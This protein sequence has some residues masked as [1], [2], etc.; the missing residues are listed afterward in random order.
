MKK[1]EFIYQVYVLLDANSPKT[2]TFLDRREPFQFLISVILSAQTTDQTVNQ[3]VPALF[4]R[5]PD[6]VS[7][8]SADYEEVCNLIRRTGFYRNKAKNIIACS[9]AL[10]GGRIP[11]TIEELVKLPGV[12]R[13]TANCVV[14]DIYQGSAVIVDTHVKRVLKRL[15]FTS[16]SDPDRI[17]AQVRASLAEEY[18]Y[19]FSMIVNLHGRLIC[20]ARKPDCAHCPLARLCPSKDVVG[21]EGAR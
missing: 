1:S 15:G 16:S 20:H 11:D 8:A 5:Y 3:V 6:A 9:K 10:A 21:Q 4:A 14:G 17:E 19:R 7:L 12:G 18:L 13:K 2:I